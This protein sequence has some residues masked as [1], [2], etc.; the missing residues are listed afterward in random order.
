LARWAFIF[1][2]CDFDIVHKAGRVNRDANG[3]SQ[4]P[5]SNE[6]DIT[7]V[8][9]HG[10][11]DLEAI[12]RWDASTYVCTLLGYFGD[13]PQGNTGS[14]NSHNDDDEVEGNGALDIHLDL[15]VMAY[16]H[17]GEVSMGLTPNEQD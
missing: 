13:V 4:N 14:G 10:K 8:R 5:S 9:W 15:L 16:L 2:E 6:E 3:L 7:S 12:P 1:Q 11:V 17:V